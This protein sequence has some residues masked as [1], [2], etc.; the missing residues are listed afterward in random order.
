MAEQDRLEIAE[1][2]TSRWRRWAEIVRLFVL[3]QR[4]RYDVDPAEYDALHRELLAACRQKQR[5]GSDLAAQ[6]FYRELEEML[7]PWVTLDSLGW[8]ERDI[9]YQLSRRGEG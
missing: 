5:A 3:R 8:A 4:G 9:V 7:A 6:P 1:A 2:F